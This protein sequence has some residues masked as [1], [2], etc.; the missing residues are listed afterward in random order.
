MFLLDHSD[1]LIVTIG[2]GEEKHLQYGWFTE[3]N[4]QVQANVNP[5][6]TRLSAGYWYY[7]WPCISM[8]RLT[9]PREW[10]SEE[11]SWRKMLLTEPGVEFNYL[12]RAEEDAE[13][14]VIVT[15]NTKDQL[16]GSVYRKMALMRQY[17]EDCGD[18][19]TNA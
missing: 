19:L 6:L 4:Q 13:E 14:D 10:R 12:R 8:T 15:I 9:L 7:C 1:G 18:E 16:A 17:A 2:E 3:E 5:L 11:A